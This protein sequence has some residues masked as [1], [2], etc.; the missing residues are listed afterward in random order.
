[1]FG[2]RRKGGPS[3]PQIFQS[4][5]WPQLPDTRPRQAPVQPHPQPYP[6]SEIPTQMRTVMPVEAEDAAVLARTA[7]EELLDKI[8]GFRSAVA[9]ALY[10][11]SNDYRLLCGLVHAELNSCDPLMDELRVPLA[12]NTHYRVLA[13]LD[14]AY[15]LVE[16]Q[17][18]QQT[19][20]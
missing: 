18:G 16:A 17:L 8:A 14:E 20:P 2:G 1:M 6:I 19:Q 5:G 11:I 9:D 13:K 7:E 3:E 4:G 10:E 15:A 12:D